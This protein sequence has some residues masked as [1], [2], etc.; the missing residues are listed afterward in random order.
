MTFFMVLYFAMY[1]GSLNT[2][3]FVDV[4]I[5]PTPMNTSLLAVPIN[6]LNIWGSKIPHVH[7]N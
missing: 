1:S 6:H 2:N 5:G 4:F 3:T 7:H